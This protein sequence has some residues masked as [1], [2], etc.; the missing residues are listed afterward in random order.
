MLEEH[1]DYQPELMNTLIKRGKTDLI[2]A[3]EP[4]HPKEGQLFTTRQPEALGLGHAIWCA[5]HLIGDEPFA[6]ILP[7]D[8][9]LAHKGCLAQLIEQYNTTGGNLVAVM[10]I[11]PELTYKY[12]ILDIETDNDKLVS[13]KGL[14]EKPKPEDAPSDLSII[15]RYILQPEI[16]SYLERFETGVGGEIQLTDAMEKLIGQQPFHGVRFDGTRYDCGHRLGFLEAN[17][18]F[19]LED[20]RFSDELKAILEKYLQDENNAEKPNALAR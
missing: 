13:I 4:T 5:K 17:I 7:D 1:F 6:V 14:V 15:G 19:G 16:F 9:V 3:I 2:D 8:V 11:P 12:G 10:N 20:E 18:A